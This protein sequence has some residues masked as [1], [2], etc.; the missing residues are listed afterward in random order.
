MNRNP[1][2]RGRSASRA[3]R[4]VLSMTATLF[5]ASCSQVSA[6]RGNIDGLTKVAEQA[7]R[8]GAIRCAPRELA[9]A[10][11]HLEFA[12]VEIDQGFWTRAKEHLDIAEANAHAAY[13]LS[14]PQKCA[15]RGF[16]EDAPPPKPGDKDGDGYLDPDDKCPDEPENY[17]GYQ[18]DD[19]CP[20][21]PDTDG[22][23]I[24]DSKDQCVLAPEDKDG[25]LDE[26]GCPDPDND[27]DT[28]ADA[29]DKDATGKTCMN[30]PED[31]DGFEDAD[32]CPDPDNDKDSVVDLEDQCP[33]EPGPPGGDK[34]GCPKKPS[35][36]IVTAKEIKITQQIHFEFDKDKIRSESFPIL[37]AV[38][39]VLKTN[40][41]IKIDVQ[42]HTDNKGAADYNKKL[43]DRRAASV[44]KYLVGKG[45][46]GAR[47]VSHG[48]GAEMPIVPNT[49]DQNRALNRRVQFVRTEAAP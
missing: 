31:P 25:Y 12:T 32:G 36:V 22:D 40:P 35:L 2:L 28:I 37:D 33:A 42:G 18:D 17:Q 15:E 39:D 34:P 16:V 27:L 45:I 24:P 10:K 49:N 14:P 6:M 26:D 23:G 46:D 47:L 38:A 29:N 21:D 44:K 13:D 1:W 4:V 5:L 3:Q 11:S 30:D 43:S 8:N 7:E 19:G 48:Y 20:D 41:N 9:L